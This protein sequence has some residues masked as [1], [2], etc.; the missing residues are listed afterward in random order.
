MS[1]FKNDSKWVMKTEKL[2]SEQT[3]ARVSY[4]PHHLR[5]K[6]KRHWPTPYI[7]SHH[8]RRHPTHRVRRRVSNSIHHTGT[9]PQK[10]P[11][12]A[13]GCWLIMMNQ[14]AHRFLTYCS[15]QIMEQQCTWSRYADVR[16][17]R[18]VSCVPTMCQLVFSF[19]ASIPRLH[20]RTIMHFWGLIVAIRGELSQAKQSKAKQ[21]GHPMSHFNNDSTCES[22]KTEKLV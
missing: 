16:A 20:R 22:W 19:L 1:H 3:R 4:Q 9:P 15:S 11:V 8:H 12:Q 2:V 7:L 18:N 13:L 21:V 17:L 14:S 10:Q 6:N 5:N